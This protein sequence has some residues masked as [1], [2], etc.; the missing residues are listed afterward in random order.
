MV[1][2][3]RIITGG[4]G[5]VTVTDFN[6]SQDLSKIVFTHPT[7]PSRYIMVS[8]STYVTNGNIG[9]FNI[10]FTSDVSFNIQGVPSQGK[11]SLQKDRV[12]SYL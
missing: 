9:G 5:K 8:E 4:S 11:T 7:N 6:G 10:E 2:G 3:S 12:V 1:L